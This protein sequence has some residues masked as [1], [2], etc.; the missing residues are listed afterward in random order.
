MNI[1]FTASEFGVDEDEFCLTV[2]VTDGDN[3]LVFSRDSE[4]G[5]DD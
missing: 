1:E 2:G 3:Y 4:P 5:E